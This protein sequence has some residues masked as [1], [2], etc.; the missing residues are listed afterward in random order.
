MILNIGYEGIHKG[1]PLTRQDLEDM[2]ET[3]GAGDATLVSPKLT[4]T[5]NNIE[6]QK[7]LGRI[8]KLF[9][10]EDMLK[11]DIEFTDKEFEA[12][13]NNNQYPNLSLGMRKSF[14]KNRKKAF[15][16]HLSFLGGGQAPKILGLNNF[17]EDEIE[18]IELNNYSE[19]MNMNLE[20]KIIAL[21]ARLDSLE[22]V[23]E[24]T[25]EESEAM[26][27]ENESKE[28][29]KEEYSEKVNEL[30]AKL[31]EQEELIKTFS[32]KEIA[33]KKENLKKRFEGRFTK[34]GIDAFFA[35]DNFSEED[36]EKWMNLIDTMIVAK[37]S[38]VD[39]SEK[40]EGTKK[41]QSVKV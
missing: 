4:I 10:K 21:E 26:A 37:P 6:T 39:F 34:E 27:I 14:I 7:N 41:R 18:V 15:L 19:E 35:V 20:E 8:N 13:Y 12:K 22:K 11:A 3:F 24:P 25:A 17:S 30:E 2:V 1:T 36:N 32:E 33:L 29:E 31:K 5:H 23:E 9:I 40:Q 38:K 28:N 16:A